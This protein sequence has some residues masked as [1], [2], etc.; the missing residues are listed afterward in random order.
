MNRATGV[1]LK[2]I[3]RQAGCSIT[4][5]SKV[6]NGARGSAGA[7]VETR[8]RILLLAHELG[9][10]P[11]F[12]ARALQEG[13]S[14]TI[15]L[16]CRLHDRSHFENDFWGQLIQGVERGVRAGRHDLLVIGPTEESNELLRG[17]EHLRQRRIDALVVP[18]DIYRHELSAVDP[19]LPIVIAGDATGF[20]FPNVQ[21]DL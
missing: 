19:H 18:A 9:Y 16:V 13:R 3:A 8:T 1:T 12:H 4:V 11:N 14:R 7:G 6:L 15:G 17:V 10:S 2:E 20:L 21:V 5:V